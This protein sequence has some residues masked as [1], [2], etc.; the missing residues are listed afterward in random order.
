[1]TLLCNGQWR[2]SMWKLGGVTP[3]ITQ[4]LA[5][6]SSESFS[7][8]SIIWKPLLR[9]RVIAKVDIFQSSSAFRR[10][11]NMSFN[12]CATFRTFLSFSVFFFNHFACVIA[13]CINFA[14]DV[15]FYRNFTISPPFPLIN[16]ICTRYKKLFLSGP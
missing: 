10:S 2:S 13:S 1:M 3:L 9:R 14:T 16:L 8:T 15:Y 6:F 5:P 11:C 7:F 12:P 4:C